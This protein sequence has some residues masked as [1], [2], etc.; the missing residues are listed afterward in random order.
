MPRFAPLLLTVI[1]L[2]ATAQFGIAGEADTTLKTC[3]SAWNGKSNHLRPLVARR[4]RLGVIAPLGTTATRDQCE[5]TFFGPKF[6]VLVDA[7]F[8]GGHV[9]WGRPMIGRET[10]GEATPNA[11]LLA[12][13][14]VRS[15]GN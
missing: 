2:G 10:I 15:V 14:F 13:G 4:A 1:G 8:S 6:R 12:D 9:R 7:R 11:L 5:F 3:I